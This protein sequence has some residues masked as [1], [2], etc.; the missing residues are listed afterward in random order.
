MENHQNEG[1]LNFPASEERSKKDALHST[2][3]EEHPN[4]GDLNSPP[5]PSR[6]VLVP[7]NLG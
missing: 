3:S 2:A 7:S 4:I 1:Q 5:C 6:M